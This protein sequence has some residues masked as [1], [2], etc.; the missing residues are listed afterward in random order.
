MDMSNT[1]RRVRVRLLLSSG[2]VAAAVG[3]AAWH[4]DPILLRI[5]ANH[6]EP[7]VR[8]Q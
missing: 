5:A 4:T 8:D 2:L 3:V 6:C 7:V 1:I